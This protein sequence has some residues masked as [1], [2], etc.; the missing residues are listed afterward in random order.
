MGD[1][2]RSYELLMVPAR[3]RFTSGA[4]LTALISP[5]TEPESL[6]TFLVYFCGIGTRITEPVERW[7]RRAGKR[8]GDAGLEKLGLALEA[9]AASESGHHSLMRADFEKLVARRAARK[10]W[11]VDVEWLLNEAPSPGAERYREVHEDV[12]GGD[13]PFAQIAIEYEIGRMAVEHGPRVVDRCVEKLGQEIIPCLSFLTEHVVADVGHTASKARELE[14]LTTE[15][16]AR[17]PAL[18][19]AGS[20][21]LDA[22]TQF[23]DDC[24][25]LSGRHR[26]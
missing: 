11:P 1:G 5:E 18:V 8:C 13:F 16:P 12:L 15:D 10:A 23:L 6:E 2:F 7:I 21:A 14:D 17:I 25:Q 9:H 22:Y 19:A 20:A 24:L 4:G 26:G 3:Q